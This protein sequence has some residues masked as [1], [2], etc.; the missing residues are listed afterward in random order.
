MLNAATALSILRKLSVLPKYP[1][2]KEAELE[3]MRILSECCYNEEHATA[4][5]QE[6]TE[7]FPLPNELRLV[8]LN[9]R[10]RFYTDQLKPIC[11]HC[12]GGGWQ[13]LTIKG[14]DYSRRCVCRRP[15]TAAAPQPPIEFP[16]PKTK[17]RT[18]S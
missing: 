16:R 13:S 8:A 2:H 9:L 6:F 10:D 12:G 5:V 14:V 18:G 3:M 1:F 4:V 7:L 17:A 11:P 15:N